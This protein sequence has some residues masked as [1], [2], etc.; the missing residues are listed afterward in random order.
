MGIIKD[1]RDEIQRLRKGIFDVESEESKYRK[2]VY[3]GRGSEYRGN[4]YIEVFDYNTIGE[5]RGDYRRYP[6]KG[7][8]SNKLLFLIVSVLGIY[9]S[10]KGN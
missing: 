3:A 4:I 1:I 5:V 10:H 9:V 2:T 7:I 8:E 6:I